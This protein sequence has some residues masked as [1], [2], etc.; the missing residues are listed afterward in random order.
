[1]YDAYN[2]HVVAVV[3]SCGC[4]GMYYTRMSHISDVVSHIPRQSSPCIYSSRLKN[5]KKHTHIWYKRRT[6]AIHTQNASAPAAPLW[7]LLL[8]KSTRVRHS[9]PL[10]KDTLTFSHT[11]HPPTPTHI[12]TQRFPP[13][14]PSKQPAI[15]TDQYEEDKKQ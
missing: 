9:L 11:H 1:M 14:L 13:S 15:M 6:N 5:H 8:L 3:A 2:I 12:H 7:L 10:T 4:G